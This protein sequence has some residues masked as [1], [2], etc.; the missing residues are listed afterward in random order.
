L[1]IAHQLVGNAVAGAHGDATTFFFPTSNLACRAEVID[2]IPFDETYSTIG[3][4]DRD[5]YARVAAA[6][7]RLIFEPAA[8]VFHFPELTPRTFVAKQ[9]RYGRGA[10]RYRIRHRSGR[11][12]RP[13]FYARLV[14]CGFDEG[15]AVGALVSAAQVAAAAGYAAEAVAAGG[16][17][18]T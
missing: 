10:Y 16:R 12:E 18:S 14:R 8:V 4:E 5:W 3:A 9:F 11:L 1:S 17:R 15:L 7:R 2:A 6:G 13:A